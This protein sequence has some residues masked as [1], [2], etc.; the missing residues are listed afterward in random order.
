MIR[1]FINTALRNILKQ[2]GYNFLNIFGMAIGLAAAAMIFLWIE[3]EITW[4]HYFPNREN[5]Y[6]VKNNH[7]YDGISFTFNETPGPLHLQ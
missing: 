5:I 4:N 2:K 3:D 6:L 7:T 1:N